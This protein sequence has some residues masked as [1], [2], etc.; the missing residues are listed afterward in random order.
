[1]RSKFINLFI[2]LSL[3]GVTIASFN[4]MEE[5]NFSRTYPEGKSEESKWIQVKR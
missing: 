4:E 3:F 1:M 2:L 5:F